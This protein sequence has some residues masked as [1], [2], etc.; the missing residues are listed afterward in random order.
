MGK[1]HGLKSGLVAVDGQAL[2]RRGR[3]TGVEKEV[4]N[5]NRRSEVVNRFEGGQVE[6]CWSD[7]T[8]SVAAVLCLDLG[9]SGIAARL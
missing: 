5:L 6:G 4:V 1:V 2:G 3:E 7:G 9:N 8:A